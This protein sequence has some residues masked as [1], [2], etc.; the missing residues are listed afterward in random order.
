MLLTPQQ[1]VWYNGAMVEPLD[2]HKRKTSKKHERKGAQS[3][4]GKSFT[5]GEHYALKKLQKYVHG[6]WMILADVVTP[7]KLTEVIE[8]LVEL[9]KMKNQTGVRAA[10]LLFAHVLGGIPSEK[11]KADNIAI[12]IQQLLKV[13]FS[14]N[15]DE[16]KAIAIVEARHGLLA[17]SG[18]DADSSAPDEIEVGSWGRASGQE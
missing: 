4:L 11:E 9:A 2:G 12:L 7:E 3:T 8:N 14:L 10:T 1:K 16:A 15:A 13:S 5:R 6:N 18:P 17:T